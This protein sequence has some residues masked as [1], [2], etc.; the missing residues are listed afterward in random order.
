MAA[1][2]VTG[3]VKGQSLS[4]LVLCRMPALRFH[5]SPPVLP[6]ENLKYE[7]LLLGAASG[8]CPSR[9]NTILGSSGLEANEGSKTP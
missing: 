8:C 1:L 5:V 4:E 7:N 3:S 6:L 9:R 2:K